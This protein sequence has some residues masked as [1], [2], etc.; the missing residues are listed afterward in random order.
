MVVL[1]TDLISVPLRLSLSWRR[2]CVSENVH[3]S[4]VT[5]HHERCLDIALNG[6]QGKDHADTKC[7]ARTA[8][9]K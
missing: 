5:M 6:D 8:S 2:S 4:I 1:V 3:T 7:N 9:K